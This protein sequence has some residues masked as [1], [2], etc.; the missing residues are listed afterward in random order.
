M[1]QVGLQFEEDPAD[2]ISDGPADDHSTSESDEDT[3][4]A[5]AEAPKFVKITPAVKCKARYRIRI[6][7]LLT[8]VPPQLAVEVRYPD[9]TSHCHAVGPATEA[10]KARQRRS[11]PLAENYFAEFVRTMLH[12]PFPRPLYVHLTVS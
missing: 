8:T 12:P 10:D 6:V 1:V 7:K 4:E 2:T 11:S 9:D 5:R 3:E